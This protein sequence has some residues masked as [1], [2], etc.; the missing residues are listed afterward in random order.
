MCARM[1]RSRL[2]VLTLLPFL[3]AVSGG[4]KPASWSLWEKYSARFIDPQ[5]R[6]IDPMR[7][8]LTTSE[9][10]SY[11]LF[12]ALA[13][14]DRERFDQVL[15]WT[16]ANLASGDMSRHLPGWQWGKAQDGQ[17]KLLDGSPAADS[18]CWI[19]YDLLEAGRLWKSPQYTLIGRAM[20]TAIAQQ[21]VARIPGFGVMLMPGPSANFI[22]GEN[23]TVNPS[24]VP[25]FLFERF[26]A[27][28]SSGPWSAIAA[29]IPRL[30]KL[31][32]R[33][34]FAMD[35]VTWEPV[36][37]FVPAGGPEPPPAGQ[38]APPA[39]GS[40]DAIRVYLWAGMT[41]SSVPTR[42]ALLSS[43]SGMSSYLAQHGAPPEKVSDQ[44]VPIQQDGPV[45]FSAAILPYLRAL[46][47]TET[48]VKQQ[49]QRID[50]Q[51]DPASGLYGK[52]PAYYDQNLI[53]FANG[54]QENK[55]RFGP[56]GQLKVEW[57][58]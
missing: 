6:V 1:T 48:A 13:D 44:G 4:C 25:L 26:A 8:G 38:P 14:N 19:A 53:L 21:E 50:G 24:Y 3:M 18:D 5:G 10:Q 20:L 47:Q 22:H 30:L 2:V 56:D 11:A 40:Y 55:F 46:P 35:W 23:W 32:N 45:G 27:V 31:S 58:H 33:G 42:A 43:L 49:Q 15:N 9:G 17:W 41:D 57:A 54:F 39:Y 12:F 34:G 16:Q 36:A 29:N 51:L 52:N 7:G 37:G 28:D